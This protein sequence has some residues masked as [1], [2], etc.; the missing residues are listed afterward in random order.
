MAK[1]VEG[2]RGEAMTVATTLGA[3]TLLE[4]G[5][6]TSLIDAMKQRIFL[7]ARTEARELMQQG[8]QKGGVLSR[9][10]GEPMAS[11]IGRRRQ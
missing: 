10:S 5:G 6:M 2:L 3:D 4:E 8:L 11:Y 1:V 9:Q 7:T